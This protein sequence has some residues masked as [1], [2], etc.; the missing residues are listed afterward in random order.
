MK[1]DMQC[2]GLTD[3]EASDRVRRRRMIV[4]GDPQ[5]EQPK[6]KE[7]AATKGKICHRKCLLSIAECTLA[8]R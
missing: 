2:V 1:E 4:C 3:E 8:V 6:E 7:L 5:T